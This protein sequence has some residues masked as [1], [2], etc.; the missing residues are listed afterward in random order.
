[1]NRFL[2]SLALALLPAS[3]FA[4][5]PV[6]HLYV[7][8]ST[9]KV[10]KGIY[11]LDFNVE[12]G[13]LSNQE[14]VAEIKNPSFLTIHPSK[15]FLYAVTEIS[16]ASGKKIGG[17]QAFQLDAK[18]GKLTPLNQQPSGGA[19]P[20]HIVTDQKGKVVLV[21]NY[22]GGS[23]SSI[24]VQADGKL[25]EPVSVIQ[26]AG[27]S[28]D[29]ARQK[30]PHA[31]SINVDPT[32]K[33]AM[34]ADLGIDKVLIYKL[35]DKGALT[36]GNPGHAS[37]APGSGPRHFAFHPDG[38]HAFVI[39]EMLMT[40]T[41]FKYDASKGSLTEIETVTTLPAGVGPGKGLSTAEVLVHPSGKFVYGSN[42]GHNTIAIF[43]F[44][45]AKGKLTPAGHQG[46]TVKT[47]RNF[48]IDP[49]GKWL[50]VGNQD[51][52]NITVF[53]VDQVTGQLTQVGEPVAT[54]TPIC[55][56]MIPKE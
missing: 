9:G 15:K 54:P 10:S 1:M 47:P 39:N 34:A 17:V 55:L 36:P 43:T 4:Q 33:F 24:P 2:W 25:G 35:D 23:V 50:L 41:S 11:R 44:D 40:V 45:A 7:G 8:T 6:W 31:H 32:N 20:C 12:T 30:Q 5:G 28:A 38:K 51:G 29:P 46:A 42:R 48:M 3:L 16:D 49:S 52:N 18:S 27:S 22:S 56:R 53:R 21:A 13:A 19:G 26:H 14:L 37:V